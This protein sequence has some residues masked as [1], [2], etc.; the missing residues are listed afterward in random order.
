[1]RT[2]QPI[3]C[4]IY[5]IT[6]T[7]NK[8]YIGQ[9]KDIKKR[10]SGRAYNKNPKLSKSFDVF[11]YSN[12]AF[13][14][15]EVC[16]ESDLYDR[17][18]FWIKHFDTFD[19]EHGLN[20]QSGGLSCTFSLQTREKQSKIKLGTHRSDETKAKISKNNACTRLGKPLTD[21][22]KRRI[23]EKVSLSLMGNKR[24]LGY[25]QSDAT[26]EKHKNRVQ[27]DEKRLKNSAASKLFWAKM[28]PEQKTAHLNKMSQGKKAKS[29]PIPIAIKINT[30]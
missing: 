1:M 18:A 19:T 27:T 9:S 16:L 17:E 20:L 28:T 6:S 13:D 8:I 29:H 14:I 3:I 22:E 25:K 11:G 26:K 2:K 15:V 12:H 4:G 24:S 5:K 10:W 7:D 30:K 21:E 23:S